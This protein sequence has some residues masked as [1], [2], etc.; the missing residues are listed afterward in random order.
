[1]TMHSGA[2]QPRRLIF[3]AGVIPRAA[4][5]RRLLTGTQRTAADKRTYRYQSAV[6]LHR[7][8]LYPD[9]SPLPPSQLHLPLLSQRSV[10]SARVKNNT[11]KDRA[12]SLL[13]NICCRVVCLS[14]EINGVLNKRA[15]AGTVCQSQR[16]FAVEVKR[17]TCPGERPSH[18]YCVYLI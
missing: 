10:S 16:E 2:A 3:S 13:T 17:H 14:L 5:M 8:R 15:A 7:F 6:V 12:P 9:P 1:M 18:Y 4:S 11:G